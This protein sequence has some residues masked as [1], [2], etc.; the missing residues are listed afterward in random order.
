MQYVICSSQLAL[1]VNCIISIL[2]VTKLSLGGGGGK[3]GRIGCRWQSLRSYQGVSQSEPLLLLISTLWVWNAVGSSC[4]EIVLLLKKHPL[5]ALSPFNVTQ[6]P[7]PDYWFL[8]TIHSFSNHWAPLWA[9]QHLE[10]EETGAALHPV[11]CLLTRCGWRDGL[12]L[13]SYHF[14]LKKHLC[15][16]C[17]F[18]N[19]HFMAHPRFWI[20]IAYG[21]IF[22]A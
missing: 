2:Q 5:P 1:E 18:L 10:L 15:Y 17:W 14:C 11:S 3:E 12:S 20:S 7:L 6:E 21:F 22:K 13:Q 4:K 9:K 19:I 8:N 16:H